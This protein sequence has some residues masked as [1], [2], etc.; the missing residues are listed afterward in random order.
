MYNSVNGYYYD[1]AW[2]AWYDAFRRLGVPGCEKIVGLV[3]VAQNA[4]WWF[5]MKDAV[6]ITERPTEL[7]RDP[8]GRM[9]C[10]TGPAIRYPDGWGLHMWHGTRVPADLIEKGWGIREIFA[11]KN[12]E[13]RRCA[14]EKRGWDWFIQESGIK[15]VASAPDPGN[16]PYHI[17][18]YDLP[19][20][21]EDMFDADARILLCVNGTEE[22]DGTRRRFGLPVPAHHTDPVAA[23]ADLYGWPEAAYRQIEVRR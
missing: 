3:Q 9:H 21:L 16:A 23:A 22:K 4:G 12:S 7:H 1:I 19:D 5:P 20:E 10:D 14:I 13:V 17:A 2:T 15:K 11:E 18:L 8:Q 6:V